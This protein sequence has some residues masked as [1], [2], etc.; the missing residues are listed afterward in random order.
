MMRMVMAVLAAVP[1]MIVGSQHAPGSDC[2]ALTRQ[3]GVTR[4][5][6]AETRGHRYCEV[7]G[8]LAPQTHYTLKLPVDGWT[9]RYVQQGCGGLCGAVPALDVP[10]FGFQCAA[11]LDG[12]LALGA[13]DGGHTG[14]DPGDGR[15]GEHDM[16]A[17]VEFGLLSEHRLNG[18]ATRLMR[19]YYGRTPA[20]RY[21]DGCSTGGRQ[22]LNLAQRFPADF[23]GILAGAPAANLTGLGMLN[24]WLVVH[25]TDA[26]GRDILT[27][28]KLPA[29][30]AAVV[31]ACGDPVPDPRRCDFDPSTVDGLSA[32]QVRAV[33]AFYAGPPTYHG[34][35]PYG[36]ELEWASEFVGSDTTERIALNYFRY[37]AYPQNPPAGFALTDVRYTRAELARLDVLG[38]AVYNATDPDLS[39]FRRHGGKLILYHGWADSSIPPAATVDY[40]AAVERR[41]GGFA[42]SQRFS[43]LY[44]VPGGYHCLIT[45][46]ELV[47]VEMLQP[48]MDWV[49]SGTAPGTLD[50]PVLSV[51]DYQVI[52]DARVAPFDALA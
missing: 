23:D 50:A 18:Q 31:A 25:N 51:P 44:M 41:A 32:A 1:T 28:D 38:D 11:A 4:A 45:A 48:L 5:A 35:V 2:G 43:R 16:R 36:S 21:F 27:P 8:V 49:E 17:R 9:G 37:L 34:G 3:P 19:A 26:R 29:L 22:G 46:T 10:L 15:W 14:T 47:F 24:A 6:E 40:Y 30:H 12:R 42:A 33:R 52:R 13:T 39:A 7:T 20:Y